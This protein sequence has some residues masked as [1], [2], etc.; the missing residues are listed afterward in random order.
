MPFTVSVKPMNG[1]VFDSAKVNIGLSLVRQAKSSH[2][3]CYDNIFIMFACHDQNFGST[4][5]VFVIINQLQFHRQIRVGEGGKWGGGGGPFV[6][7]IAM[8]MGCCRFFV[9]V[10][11]HRFTWVSMHEKPRTWAHEHTHTHAHTCTHARTHTH[12]TRHM[13]TQRRIQTHRHTHRP[14][15]HT[16]KQNNMFQV[17]YPLH[18]AHKTIAFAHAYVHNCTYT[19]TCCETTKFSYPTSFRNSRQQHRLTKTS[20][21]SK[22]LHTYFDRYQAVIYKKKLPVEAFGEVCSQAV[23]NPLF[24]E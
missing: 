17:P 3:N 24:L 21:Y 2:Q 16:N 8:A 13:L 23:G 20:L 18:P 4:L 1:P 15:T 7:K 22:L 10:N 11:G 19:H 14:K 6:T 12:H 5:V 9:P